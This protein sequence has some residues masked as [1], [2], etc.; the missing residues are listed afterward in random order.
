M[1]NLNELETV[2]IKNK[3]TSFEKMMNLAFIRREK[4]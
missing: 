2:Y 1:V 4:S 3:I